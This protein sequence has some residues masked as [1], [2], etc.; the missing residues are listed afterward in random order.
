[1]KQQLLRKQQVVPILKEKT[2]RDVLTETMDTLGIELSSFDIVSNHIIFSV[3]GVMVRNLD[4]VL[5]VGQ[6]VKLIPAMKA[7]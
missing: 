6:E 5:S 3:D 1:M 4:A 2:L 7:G